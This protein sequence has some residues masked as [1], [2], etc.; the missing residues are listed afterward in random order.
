MTN[1]R[2]VTRSG[3]AIGLSANGNPQSRRLIV[4][5]HPTPG[6]ADFD[7]NPTLTS[8]RGVH[9]VGLDRPGYGASDPLPEGETPGIEQRADDIA[10]FLRHTARDARQIGAETFTQAGV[11][12]WAS[13]GAVALCL[14]ARHPHLVDRVA[15]VGLA[16][17][18][19]SNR[20][21]LRGRTYSEFLP[22]TTSNLVPQVRH[23]VDE[24]QRLAYAALGIDVA[25]PALS[26]PGLSDRLTRMLADAYLQGQVGIETDRQALKNVSWQSELERITASVLLIYG[27]HDTLATRRDGQHFRRKIPGA[28]IVTAQNSGRLALAS[29]WGRILEHVAPSD[30]VASTT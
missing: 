4:F 7:P 12:G 23:Q 22:D 10:E 13:G 27:D 17:P 2:F 8:K 15:V 5:C 19:R 30:C 16:N 20:R 24:K 14:A 21:Q 3:R 28:R 1:R 18:T 6:A 9:I 26:L 25:D 11:V 29:Y